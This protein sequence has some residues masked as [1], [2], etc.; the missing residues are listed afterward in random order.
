MTAGPPKQDL[1]QEGPSAVSAFQIDRKKCL[2]WSFRRIV[3]F[4][5]RK[6]LQKPTNSEGVFFFLLP[7]YILAG[8]GENISYYC[9]P[10]IIQLAVTF[11][12][13]SAPHRN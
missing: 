11:V 7:G 13:D 6:L 8:I 10:G 1:R 4:V 9:R 3:A 5:R 12:T 2:T